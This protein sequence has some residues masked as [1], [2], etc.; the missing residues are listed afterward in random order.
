MLP[1]PSSAEAAVPAIAARHSL[2]ITTVKPYRMTEADTPSGL[3]V[4]YGA[5]ARNSFTGALNAL[6]AV[7]GEL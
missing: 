6:L 4:G 2:A 1:L 7:L 5:P 3:I